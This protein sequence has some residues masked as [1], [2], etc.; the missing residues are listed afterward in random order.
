MQTFKHSLVV[1]S[2]YVIV[3]N[4]SVYKSV[5]SSIRQQTQLQGRKSGL[6]PKPPLELEHLLM[7]HPFYK[8]PAS[9]VE[10][11]VATPS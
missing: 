8:R 9:G 5:Y 11:Q 2:W 1:M 10:W 4:N 3:E 6:N 7:H